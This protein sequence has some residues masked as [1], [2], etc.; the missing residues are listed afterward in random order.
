MKVKID[1]IKKNTFELTIKNKI[2][3]VVLS[4]KELIDLK[5]EIEKAEEDNEEK[6]I[7]V[8]LGELKL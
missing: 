1:R 5:K 2:N 8:D 7:F 4:K 3:K 6:L